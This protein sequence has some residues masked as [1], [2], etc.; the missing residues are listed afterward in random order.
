MLAKKLSEMIIISPSLDLYNK[1]VEIKE[2]LKEEIFSHSKLFNKVLRRIRLSSFRYIEGALPDSLAFYTILAAEFVT[3]RTYR[4][5][6]MGLEVY[7]IYFYVNPYSDDWKLKAINLL[8]HELAHIAFKRTTVIPLEEEILCSVIAFSAGVPRNI[9]KRAYE[10]LHKIEGS[11]SPMIEVS[12]II[13]IAIIDEI[14][15]VEVSPRK[16]LRYIKDKIKNFK[17]SREK[18]SELQK[19]NPF[20]F[21]LFVDERYISSLKHAV[22]FFKDLVSMKRETTMM[23]SLLERYE[24]NKIIKL[25]AGQDALKVYEYMRMGFLLFSK[26]FLDKLNIEL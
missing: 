16:L 9:K 4:K 6:I 24:K 12:D 22:N 18:V 21:D 17:I 19:T 8:L 20:F 5:S 7:D 23:Y 13:A 2:K 10:I 25:M 11:E 3:G 26:G 1:T 14:E 15:D